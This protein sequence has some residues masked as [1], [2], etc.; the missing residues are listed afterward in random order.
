MILET[1]KNRAE[2]L[3]SSMQSLRQG[4]NSPLRKQMTLELGPLPHLPTLAPPTLAAKVRG[5]DSHKPH[6]LLAFL[7]FTLGSRANNRGPLRVSLMLTPSLSVRAVQWGSTAS[8]APQCLLGG[9]G[10]YFWQSG[11][12]ASTQREAPMGVARPILCSGQ[13]PS[14]PYPDFRIANK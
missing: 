1:L 12:P 11:K 10:T 14:Q 8:G 13:E 5:V 9:G 2:T 7:T 3:A 4:F 6:L